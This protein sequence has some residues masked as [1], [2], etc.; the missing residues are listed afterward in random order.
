M[1]IFVME[2]MRVFMCAQDRH[3]VFRS[4]RKLI[5]GTITTNWIKKTPSNS[6]E[7]GASIRPR[8]SLSVT[9]FLATT[10]TRSTAVI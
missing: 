5:A 1:S 3:S 9:Y 2:A 4:G 8:L 7:R 6:K 10:G